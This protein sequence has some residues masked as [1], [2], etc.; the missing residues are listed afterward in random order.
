MN[1]YERLQQEHEVQKQLAAQ[2]MRTSGDSS[3]RRELFEE[4]K[5]EAESHA[6]AEE[7]T[8]YAALIEKQ[9]S[10][11]QAR[12][13]ISEHKSAAD[14]IEELEE[15]EMGN[16]GWIRKFEK[17]KDE[18][19]HHIAEE[20]ND[21]FKMARRLIDSDEANELAEKFERRKQSEASA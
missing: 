10:Q 2:I 7:Q 14:L 11:E 21:V 8:F 6:A 9:E 13:S 5:T 16:G 20:E 19:E 3:E 4:F 15:T 1:I 17:L 18:L 12:H